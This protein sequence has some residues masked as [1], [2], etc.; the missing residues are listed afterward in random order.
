MSS[1][2]KKIAL[3]TGATSGIGKN[4]AYKLLANGIDVIFTGRNFDGME[5]EI[6]R[7]SPPYNSYHFIKADLLLD[8]D[9]NKLIKRV[10]EITDRIDILVHSAGIIDIGSIEESD[11][12][13]LETMFKLNVKAP[14]FISQKLLPAIKKQK[15][16]IVFINSTAGLDS[17]ANISQY[18]ASKHALTAITKSLREEAAPFGI[19]VISIHPGGTDTPMQKQIQQ[20]EGKKYDPSLFMPPELVAD[21]VI[22][23]IKSSNSSVALDIIIKPTP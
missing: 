20:L 4:I 10:V 12:S 13:G 21:T 19:K 11:I 7:L 8:E 2:L 3:V 17:W 15:G 6:S 22:Q 5:K 9:M 14:Y 16:I 18:A 1:S 23:A